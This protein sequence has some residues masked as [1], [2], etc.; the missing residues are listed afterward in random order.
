M[1]SWGGNSGFASDRQLARGFEVYG[2]IARDAVAQIAWGP[3]P[4]ETWLPSFWESD[5]PIACAV[6]VLQTAELIRQ[7]KLTTD[8]M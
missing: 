5:A 8:V 4:R 2:G 3:W 7:I 6:D 1:A